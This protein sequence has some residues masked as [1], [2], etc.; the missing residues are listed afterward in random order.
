MGWEPP[1]EPKKEKLCP[2]LESSTAIPEVWASSPTLHQGSPS[3]RTP[4][5]CQHSSGNLDGNFDQKLFFT[6]SPVPPTTRIPFLPFESLITAQPWFAL[7]RQL[8]LSHFVTVNV[9]Q[10]CSKTTILLPVPKKWAKRRSLL[11]LDNL[12]M[13]L[14]ICLRPS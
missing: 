6:L 8:A 1:P 10:F 12:P 9:I 11:N 2:P 3:L 4:R 14:D 7:K 5:R 13:W